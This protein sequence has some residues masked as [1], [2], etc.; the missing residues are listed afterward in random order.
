MPL[1]AGEKW[2]IAW[3]ERLRDFDGSVLVVWAAEDR[4]M[5]REHGPRP[6]ALYPR[7]RL[8]EIADSSTL[9]PEDR[10]ELLARVLTDFLIQ[11]GAEPDRH[12][13]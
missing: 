1:A 2:W 4:L 11:T 7:G 12:V 6:A 3:S 8:I 5:P 13:R 10:P 9:V